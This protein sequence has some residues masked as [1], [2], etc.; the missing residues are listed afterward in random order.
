VQIAINKQM[1]LL[2]FA[3]NSPG[4]NLNPIVLWLYFPSSETLFK[5]ARNLH[6]PLLRR[7]HFL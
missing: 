3:T 1:N 6:D 5:L 2:R 4:K 7:S